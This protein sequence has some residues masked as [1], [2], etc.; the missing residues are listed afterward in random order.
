MSKETEKFD[1]EGEI[2]F[3]IDFG[4]NMRIV[5]FGI[6]NLNITRSSSGIK[7]SWD[8]KAMDLVVSDGRNWWKKLKKKILC[9]LLG[10]HRASVS[11][12]DGCSFTSIC[13]LC[14]KKLLKDS[15]GNWF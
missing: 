1:F 2:K 14:G 5:F 8:A 4:D 13:K 7:G 3:M 12:W 15:Q 11:G 9:D 10:W 6:D